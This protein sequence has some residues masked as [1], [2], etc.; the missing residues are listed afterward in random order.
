MS[1]FRSPFNLSIVQDV[2]ED[3]LAFGLATPRAMPTYIRTT[4]VHTTGEVCVACY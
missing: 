3:Y 1:W 2:E 4:Y